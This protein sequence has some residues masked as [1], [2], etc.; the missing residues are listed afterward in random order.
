[1]LSFE[2]YLVK[3]FP[4]RGILIL[5]GS[6]ESFFAFS[7]SFAACI[8]VSGIIVQSGYRHIF[9]LHLYF[10]NFCFLVTRIVTLNIFIISRSCEL[11]GYSGASCL[12]LGTAV[13]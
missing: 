6:V 4:T 7:F 5:K 2:V 12:V 3:H 8:S 1:M 10:N 13:S 11:F 9:R